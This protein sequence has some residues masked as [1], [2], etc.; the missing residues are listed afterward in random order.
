ME[1]N[2]NSTILASETY[3]WQSQWAF[4]RPTIGGNRGRDR[5]EVYRPTAFVHISDISSRRHFWL[6]RDPNEF[7]CSDKFIYG[8][9]ETNGFSTRRRHLKRRDPEGEEQNVEIWIQQIRD[10]IEIA[11]WKGGRT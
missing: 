3:P 7:R 2:G 6:S 4:R 10:L 8:F 9:K 11:E 1:K 5:L